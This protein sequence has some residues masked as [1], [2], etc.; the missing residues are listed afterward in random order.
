MHP[1]ITPDRVAVVTGGASG[2]G[3]AASKRF[4][5]AGMHVVIADLGGDRLEAAAAELASAGFSATAM[6]ADVSKRSDV[7][8]LKAIADGLG[9]VTVLMN[10]AGREGGGGLFAGEDVWHKTLDTNLWGP[11]HGIQVFVPDMISGDEPAAVINTGS[12]QGITL[13]PGDTAYNVSKAGLKALTE[14]LSHDLVAK[15]KGRVTAHLLIPGFTY[16]GFTKARGVDEK[17]AGAWTP[18]QVAGF[19]LKGMASDDFYIL[20]PDNEVDRETDLKRM[21]WGFGDIVENRPALSR[22]HPGHKDDFRKF[23]EQ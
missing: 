21:R 11:I 12:K 2:I 18:D 14:L 17:P 4:A 15:T 1:A 13:P 23:M 10:N 3:F 7:E 22:W 5:E 6:P 9:T 16:T 8:A 19:L 20:C